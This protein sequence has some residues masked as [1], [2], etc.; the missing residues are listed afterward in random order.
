MVIAYRCG[1]GTPSRLEE[2]GLTRERPTWENEETVNSV[3]TLSRSLSS[4]MLKALL[5]VLITYRLSPLKSNVVWRC[6]LK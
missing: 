2:R 1:E 3:G 5:A 6:Q 4:R